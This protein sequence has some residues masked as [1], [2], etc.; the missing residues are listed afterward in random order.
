MFTRMA[1][2]LRLAGYPRR[3]RLPERKHDIGPR[4]THPRGFH[5]TSMARDTGLLGC[6]GCCN[7]RQHDNEQDITEARI[8]HLD[9]AYSGLLCYSHTFG[10]CSWLAF[11]QRLTHKLT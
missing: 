9:S 3:Q 1:R 2:H 7:I 5:P 6:D 4:T 8:F 10:L 11:S